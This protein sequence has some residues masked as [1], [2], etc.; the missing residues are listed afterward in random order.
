MKPP[1][2]QRGAAALIAVMLLF[3][4]V[5]V[6]LAWALTMATS[7]VW[8]THA[9]T[10]GAR[11]LFLAE[12]AVERASWRYV[13]GTACADLAGDGPHALAGGTFTVAASYVTE[14]DGVT[15]LPGN[16]CRIRAVGSN[17]AATRTVEAIIQIPAGGGWVVGNG[18]TLLQCSVSG[19][20]PYAGAV[21][22]VNLNG[23]YC[24]AAND[25][26]VVGDSGVVGQW[27]GNAWVFASLGGLFAYRDVACAAGASEP[28]HAVGQWF[29]WQAASI[30]TSGAGWSTSYLPF[31]FGFGALSGVAC[32]SAVCYAV[33]E[34]GVALRYAGAWSSESSGTTTNLHGVDCW[35]DLNCWA[36]ADRSGNSFVFDRRTAGGWSPLVVSSPSDRQNLNDVSCVDGADCWA[37]GDRQGNRFTF[38]HWNGLSWAPAPLS[39]TAN[40]AD[41]NGVHCLDTNDCWSVGDSGRVLHWDGSSW[42]LV[43][44]G[45]A[46]TLQNVHF[47]PSAGGGV[48]GNVLVSWREVVS[49]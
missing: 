30:W 19:C 12:S 18:G 24:A 26:W 3:V 11:A 16:R 38:V 8:D 10:S 5:A 6:I 29:F 22:A 33:G 42:S 7:E 47:P 43:S 36:V 48:G 28:C 35:D 17:A 25:C 40:R 49:P 41:L 15:A 31:P 39:D 45:T 34:S 32:P 9:E 13:N 21:P 2:R 23:V 4:F 14:F 46:Q 20:T 37:V 27:D 44:S 1:C